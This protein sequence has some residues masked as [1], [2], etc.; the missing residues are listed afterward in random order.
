MV[1]HIA[2]ASAQHASWADFPRQSI[3]NPYVREVDQPIDGI[4][5]RQVKDQAETTAMDSFPQVVG[6]LLATPPRQLRCS[7]P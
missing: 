7:G 5:K 3:L 1:S 6:E 2:G 4:N